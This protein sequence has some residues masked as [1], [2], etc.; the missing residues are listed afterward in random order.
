MSFSTDENH[1]GIV[2][3]HVFKALSKADAAR[4]MGEIEQALTNGK[5][6]IILELNSE[7]ATGSH[8]YGYLEKAFRGLRTLAQKL[9]GDLKYVLPAKIASRLPGTLSDMG[10]AVKALAGAATESEFRDENLKMR[11]QMIFQEAQ[12]KKLTTEVN[13]LT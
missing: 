4:L 9:Q 6:K 11:E 5:P 13:L 8:G 1:E 10:A 7:A 3:Y 2:V 12:I